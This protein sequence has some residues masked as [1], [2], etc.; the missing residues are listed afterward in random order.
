MENFQT[1]ICHYPESMFS[2]RLNQLFDGFY[3]R[4]SDTNSSTSPFVARPGSHGP[5]K[6]FT[7]PLSFGQRYEDMMIQLGGAQL[8]SS[9]DHD[10]VA[11]FQNCSRETILASMQSVIITFAHDAE[12]LDGY[13]KFFPADYISFGENA[14]C[15]CLFEKNLN[16]ETSHRVAYYF[17]PFLLSSNNVRFDGSSIHSCEAP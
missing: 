14:T 17:N 16:N 3:G 15:E 2:V 11:V 1:N 6:L 4:F 8:V 13:L 7:G 12:G 5:K 10:T 9:R